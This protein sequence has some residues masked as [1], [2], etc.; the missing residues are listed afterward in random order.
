M[1]SLRDIYTYSPMKDQTHLLSQH[2]DE[3]QADEVLSLCDLS[4]YSHT[5]S[6]S[7][8]SNSSKESDDTSND[9]F[10]FFTTQNHP[11]IDDIVFCGKSI[12]CRE[13]PAYQVRKSRNTCMSYFYGRI[14]R[15]SSSK[16]KS[17]GSLSNGLEK[18]NASKSKWCLFMFGLQRFSVPTNM[19]LDDMKY[20]QSRSGAKS[21]EMLERSISDSNKDKGL[22]YLLRSL[23]CKSNYSLNVLD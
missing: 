4:I 17:H 13:T 14:K 2:E 21:L 12:P 6:D 15:S 22:S 18:T 7:S 5:S 8:N 11:K 20:R 1:I 16:I 9:S 3:D 10:E 19:K 23:S